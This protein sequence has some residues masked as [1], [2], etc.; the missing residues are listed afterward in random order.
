MLLTIELL[1]AP[2]VCCCIVSAFVNFGVPKLLR[3][4]QFLKLF[5]VFTNGEFF[6]YIWFLFLGVLDINALYCLTDNIIIRFLLPSVV[7]DF[8]SFWNLMIFFS[9]LLSDFF[10]RSSPLRGFADGFDGY[11]FS[12]LTFYMD[13]APA[14]DT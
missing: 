3:L 8:L 4:S 5:V 12:S 9:L 10:I 11:T 1:Y 7:Q 6:N 14:V 13:S 2:A